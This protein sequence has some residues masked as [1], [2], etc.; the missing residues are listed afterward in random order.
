MKKEEEE[1]EGLV[2]SPGDGGVCSVIP[3]VPTQ[4]NW[5][6]VTPPPQL[7]HHH[8]T[9]SSLRSVFHPHPQDWGIFSR[10]IDSTRCRNCDKNSTELPVMMREVG[11]LIL[12]FLRQCQCI[13][14][15]WPEIG[16]HLRSEWSPSHSPTNSSPPKLSIL[17]YY[18]AQAQVP[19][20]SPVLSQFWFLRPAVSSRHH[21]HQPHHHPWSDFSH[22]TPP[23]LLNLKGSGSIF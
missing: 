8:W 4:I 16:E 23:G 9:V 17:N 11:W 20:V 6:S 12:I 13:P 18:S 7:C 15:S 21:P 1:E 19:P 3:R 2:G 22:I 5:P 14:P 10:L